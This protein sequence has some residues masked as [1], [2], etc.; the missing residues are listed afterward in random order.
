MLNK[1]SRAGLL[2][3]AGGVLSLIFITGCPGQRYLAGGQ[4]GKRFFI[5]GAAYEGAFS[6]AKKTLT[7]IGFQ[8]N[9]FYI[10]TGVIR[11]RRGSGFTE[12]TEI[13]ILI[14]KDTP[15][16]L[17]L[18]ISVKSSKDHDKFIAEFLQAYGKYVK[19]VYPEETKSSGAPAP[20][21][22]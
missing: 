10:E 15:G 22:P 16:R 2:S 11:A 21:T 9:Q 18:Q 14:E 12:V 7:E 17:S 19:I 5:E 1:I 20:S 13:D 8:I 6:K 3:M 4:E